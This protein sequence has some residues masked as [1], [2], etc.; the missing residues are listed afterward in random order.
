[1]P[2]TLAVHLKHWISDL[3]PKFI[4]DVKTTPWIYENGKQIPG[5]VL[6][7]MV[8]KTCYDICGLKLTP[9]SLRKLRTTYVMDTID[10]LDG[11]LVDKLGLKME[12]AHA[13]GHSLEVM[14][15]YYVIKDTTKSIARS[16]DIIEKTN[17]EIF[18]K[19]GNSMEVKDAILPICLPKE[20]PNYTVKMK[21]PSFSFNKIDRSHTKKE[22]ETDF[23]S[24]ILFD[25]SDLYSPVEMNH[26][27]VLP[28]NTF[29]LPQRS[30]NARH[31]ISHMINKNEAIQN[32][33][34]GE[35]LTDREIFWG[36]FLLRN[37]YGHVGGLED[38][39]VMAA[40]KS[41]NPAIQALNVYILHTEGNH[42]VTVCLGDACVGIWV[43]DSLACGRVAEDI[44]KQ[45]E[46]VTNEDQFCLAPTQQQTNSQDCGLFAIAFAVDLVEGFNPCGI[47]Y[48]ESLMRE[49]LASCIRAEHILPFPRRLKKSTKAI[50]VVD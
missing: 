2:G 31:N 19:N 47:Q 15:K 45:I 12:Y 48:D 17:Q 34:S 35:W 25:S 42:W 49:H 13:S 32:I 44:K 41:L 8:S 9:L 39:V 26:V 37:Q 40:G 27:D 29:S 16:K 50:V 33:L 18:G 28:I 14:L 7:R 23:H 22:I 21:Q 43:Y 38:T 20:I 24:D 10:E 6:G 4:R 30:C 11:T 1:M 36:L 46:H 5:K 3:L